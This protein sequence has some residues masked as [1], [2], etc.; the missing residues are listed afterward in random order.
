MHAFVV[1]YEQANTNNVISARIEL[2]LLTSPKAQ[3]KNVYVDVEYSLILPK[4]SEPLRSVLVLS[5]ALPI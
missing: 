1:P 4:K 5:I 2:I 3:C